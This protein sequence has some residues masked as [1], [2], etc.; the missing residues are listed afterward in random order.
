MSAYD[1]A[2]DVFFVRTWRTAGESITKKMKTDSSTANGIFRDMEAI[3]VLGANTVLRYTANPK[4]LTDGQVA[5]VSLFTSVEELIDTKWDG[6]WKFAV[7]RNPYSIVYSEW[8]SLN[9]LKKRVQS[10]Y[11]DDKVNGLPRANVSIARFREV[12]NDFNEYVKYKFHE[13]IDD[14]IPGEPGIA[15]KGLAGSLYYANGSIGVNEVLYYEDL[16][17]EWNTKV[18]APKGFS[19]NVL[20][21][22]NQTNDED[23]EGPQANLHWTQAYNNTS[24]NLVANAYCA[25]IELFGYSFSDGDNKPRLNTIPTEASVEPFG[26]WAGRSVPSRRYSSQGGKE[27]SNS[28]EEYTSNRMILLTKQYTRNN[29]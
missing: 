25:D 27:G 3:Q 13:N 26:P 8:K 5:N 17:N 15:Q 29:P 1:S 22:L 4:N 21:V 19:N 18:A 16:N 14:V 9:K 6:S 10:L 20:V 28:V 7:V 23:I 11:G 12:V 2:K 24:I